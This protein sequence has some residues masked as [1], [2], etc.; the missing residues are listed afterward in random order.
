MVQAIT[1]EATVLQ[2]IQQEQLKLEHPR[3][4]LLY[5]LRVS[6]RLTTTDDWKHTV[7]KELL[8]LLL[9]SSS[10]SVEEQ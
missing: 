3:I 7:L 1:V 8:L 5:Q 10:V 6:A 2:S 4:L 9:M